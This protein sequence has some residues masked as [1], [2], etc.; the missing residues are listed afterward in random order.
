M[1]INDYKIGDRI[2]AIKI[3]DKPELS[4]KLG[5]VINTYLQP[6]GFICLMI[7]FDENFQGH[8]LSGKCKDGHGWN[9]YGDDII[10]LVQLKYN[11]IKNNNLEKTVFINI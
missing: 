7:R 6:G 10:E 2:K 5:T 3:L 11:I 9:I 8:S 4:G 1:N